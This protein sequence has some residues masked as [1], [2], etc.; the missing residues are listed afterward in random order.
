MPR[1]LFRN[2]GKSIGRVFNFGKR[3]AKRRGG[4]L[5]RN[6]G[7]DIINFG[8]NELKTAGKNL[9][10]GRP[11]KLI[12]Q[13]TTL[14]GRAVSRGKD[15]V[16]DNTIKEGKSLISD[17]AKGVSKLAS[18]GIDKLPASNRSKG[19]LKQGADELIGK[20]ANT[21]QKKITRSEPQVDRIEAMVR[22]RYPNYSEERIRRIVSDVKKLRSGGHKASPPPPTSSV[23]N[24]GPIL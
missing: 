5:L 6:I 2:L 21:L 9:L 15:I 3:Q 8:K 10:S 13:V 22:K 18:K 11:D 7:T 17:S 20:G 19:I 4:R 24:R 16:I 1:S 23:Q 14:P 12:D